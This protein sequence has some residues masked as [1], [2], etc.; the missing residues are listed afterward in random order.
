MS[1]A[2]V[3]YAT[4]NK[5]A[6]KAR[7]GLLAMGRAAAESGLDHELSELVK[8]RVSQLNGCA[9]CLQMHVNDLRKDGAAQ[10]R[11]DLLPAWREVTVYSEKE[12]AALAW[13]EALTRFGDH[14]ATEVAWKAVQAHFSEDEAVFLTVAIANI[15]AWN[16]LGVG[17][18]FT[19]QPAV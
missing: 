13:A 17:L 16:R 2:R 19:P 12:R 10:A 5:V 9:F 3:E 15:N 8:L 4:F 18:N 7:D 6:A 11:I 1:N 14:E